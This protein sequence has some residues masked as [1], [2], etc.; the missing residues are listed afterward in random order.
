MLHARMLTVMSRYLVVFAYV[1]L[2]NTGCHRVLFRGAVAA[3]TVTNYSN[4]GELRNLQLI[5]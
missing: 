4:L 5:L 2:A 1:S 3:G